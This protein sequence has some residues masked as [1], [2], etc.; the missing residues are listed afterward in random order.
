MK[1]RRTLGRRGSQRER[2]GVR[3]VPF[4]C[5]ILLPAAAVAA[6]TATRSAIPGQ[7]TAAALREVARQTGVDIL[8]DPVAV[9]GRRSP[10]VP[11]QLGAEEAARRLVAASGLEVVRDSTG[12][13]IVRR[14]PLARSVPP[15]LRAAPVGAVAARPSPPPAFPLGSADELVVTGTRIVSGFNAPTPVTV[16]NAD[17]L[18]AVSPNNLTEALDVLPAFAGG[19]RTAN[20]Q[21]SANAGNNGQNLLNLRGLGTARNLIL[22]DG[23]RLPSTTTGGGVDINIIPQSSVSRVDV[24]TGGASAAYGSDAVAGVVN[25]V[26]DT[27]FEGLKGEVRGGVSSRGDLPSW[28]GSAALGKSFAGGRA[29]LILSG[30]YFTQQGLWVGDDTHRQWFEDNWGLV[31]NPVVGASPQFFVAKDLRSSQATEGGLVSSGPLQGLRFLPGGQTSQLMYGTPLGVTFMGGGGGAS[32][33][34][35][36]T[37]DQVRE[38]LFGHLSVDLT[39]RLSVFGEAMYARTHVTQHHFYNATFGAGTGFTVFRDNAFLPASVLQRM[40]AANV[41]S[42]PVGR[43]NADFPPVELEDFHRVD[44]FVAGFDLDLGEGWKLDGYYTYSKFDQELRENNLVSLRR[45]YA[46]VDAVRNATGQIVCRSTLSGFDVGCVPLDIFGFGSPS[47]EAIRYVT[48]DSVQYLTQTQKVAALNLTG[49]LGDRLQ[50]F[51]AGPISV[52]TGIEYRKETADQTS[53]AESQIVNDFTGVRGFPPSQQGRPGG[54]NLFNPLP[55]AGAYSVKEVYGEAGVPLLRDLP[56]ARALDLSLA[57]RYADYN[58]SGGVTTWKY[59]FTYDLNDQIRLRLTK[60]RD[61]RAPNLRE[62]FNPSMQGFNNQVYFGVS[63]PALI[64]NTGNPDLKPER[65]TTLTYGAVY[66]PRWLSG[67]QAS[68]DYFDIKIVDAIGNLGNITT[69]CSQ[70]YELACQYI[71]LTPTNT[72]VIRSNTLNL[73]ELATEGVDAEVAYSH[74]AFGGRF[75]YR[76]LGNHL[77]DAYSINPPAAPRPRIDGPDNPKWRALIHVRFARDDWSLFVQQRL[78][79][80]TLNNPDQEEGVYI[81]ENDIPAMAYT[82]LGG[83][84]RLRALGREQ[85]LFFNIANLFDMDPPISPGIPTNFNPNPVQTAYDRLGRM[86]SAGIRFKW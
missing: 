44:R 54:F 76:L 24:L 49:D 6:E 37:P 4:L 17:T 7:A 48:G 18:R 55:L 13:L 70:G 26:L 27:R 16:A 81:N 69:L 3:L 74:A 73:A 84:Y 53:D 31:A 83:A 36:F 38:N 58:L 21:T 72:L 1:F 61:I 68:V 60:S 34:V 62:L 35:G 65:A 11:A 82:S 79:S 10:S 85:E 2:L 22:L 86:F 80:Q 46:A 43:Y 47:V 78:I 23:R 28:G 5:C 52:A 25:F 45:V 41:Q 12:A 66:R 15:A 71:T 33:I 63:L 14:A 20:P 42:I 59:G 30:E 67:F 32:T 8:F 9:A 77:I 75:T 19:Q 29:H 56:A 64:I 57:V 51:G 39:D 40:V 50:I